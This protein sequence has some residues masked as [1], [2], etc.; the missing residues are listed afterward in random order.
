MPLGS[1]SSERRTVGSV[2]VV[3]G[4]SVVVVGAT[5]SKTVGGGVVGVAV[6]NSVGSIVGAA[7]GGIVGVSVRYGVDWHFSFCCQGDGW[8]SRRSDSRG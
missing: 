8:R 1:P 2:V 6:G 7:V 3:V 4:P 5:V